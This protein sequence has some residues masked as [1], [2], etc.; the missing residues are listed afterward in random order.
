M[1]DIIL[2]QLSDVPLSRRQ[3]E[4]VERKGKGHPDSICDAMMDACSVALCQAYLGSFGRVLHH[5]LD[6]AMLVAGHTSPQFG[7]GHCDL[8]MR[9]VLGDRATTVCNGQT[10]PVGEIVETAARQWIGDHLRFVDPRKHVV[11]QNEIQP[12]SPELVDIFSRSKMTANDTSAAVGFAPLTETERL[13]LVAEQRL[14]SPAFKSQ[15]PEAGEDVKVMAVRR[16]R[17]LYMT[18]AIAF[19]DRFIPDVESYFRRKEEIR[20]QI[21]RYLNAQLHDLDSVQVEV[22]TLDD[23]NRGSGGVYL[24]VLGTS[25]EGGDGGEVGRGNHVNGIISLCRPMSSEAAAGKNPVSHVGKIYSVLAQQIAE[26]VYA[27]CGT[28]SEA[29]VCLC[30]QIGRPVDE[31]WS[32]SLSLVLVPGT[33]LDDLRPELNE[34]VWKELS[35]VE[36]LTGRLTRGEIPI[37]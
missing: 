4:V 8:P 26:R 17:M 28:V 5:N 1:Q 35:N 29:Y 16:G 32:L 2:E 30:S 3:V 27:S 37:C 6:K 23:P 10:I 7:G 19:V 21:S 11:F 24:T 25:A 34:L 12:G 14:N 13:V 31:P 18:I 9:I 20:D 33:S 22:N 36:Q 15:Y